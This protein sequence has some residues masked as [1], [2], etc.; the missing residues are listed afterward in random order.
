MGVSRR[1]PAMWPWIALLLSCCSAE[2]LATSMRGNVSARALENCAPGK[3]NCGGCQ[4]VEPTTC[5]WCHGMGGT[6]PVA[7]ASEGPSCGPGLVNCGFC[8]CTER[9]SCA[10][11]DGHGGP[12]A[13]ISSA[14][15]QSV[16]MAV[17][18]ILIFEHHLR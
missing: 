8:L 7:P 18:L 3:V 16:G 2:P 5:S 1:S 4:C 12:A 10:V 14:H 6:S 11:C 17:L 15:M 13:I 9:S